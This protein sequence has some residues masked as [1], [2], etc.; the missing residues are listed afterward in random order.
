MNHMAVLQQRWQALTARERNLLG[1]GIALIAFALFWWL[2]LSPALRTLS[3][4]TAEHQRL[5][6]QMRQMQ[7]LQA[8]ARAL[9]A[10]PHMQR[11]DALRTLQALARQSFGDK[12]QVQN[13]GETVTVT[14]RGVNAEA[15]AQWL[16]QARVDARATAREAHLTRPETE[17]GNIAQWDGSL[18]MA[19]PAGQGG[20]R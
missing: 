20:G 3:T 16:A 14:M 2:A 17:T 5:D 6:R 1:A 13:M 7:T 8:Q 11:D 9:Q 4:A 18:V 12:A 15:L 10:Q 19:L